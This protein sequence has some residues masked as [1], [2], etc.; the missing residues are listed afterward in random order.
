MIHWKVQLHGYFEG[1]ISLRCK[2]VNNA[3]PIQYYK[4]HVTCLFSYFDL[5]LF[6]GMTFKIEGVNIWEDVLSHDLA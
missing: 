6:E 2:F 4:P 5:F 1:K 3:A